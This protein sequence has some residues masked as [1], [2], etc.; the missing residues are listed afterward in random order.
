[1]QEMSD[2]KLVAL[3]RAGQ[4]E[5]FGH[6]LQRYQRMARFVAMR[7]VRDDDTACEM[8]QQAALQAYLSFRQLRHEGSFRSWFHGIVRNVC[9]SHA[10]ARKAVPISLDGLE[11]EGRQFDNSHSLRATPDPL[12]IAEK[13]Q[14][15]RRV[16]DAVNALPLE[17]RSVILLFYYDHLNL[18]EIALELNTTVPAVKN[19][20]YKSRK[21][22]IPLLLPLNPEM[23][24]KYLHR[25]RSREMKTVTVADV[26]R[27]ETVGKG[28]LSFVVLIDEVG[29]RILSIQVGFAEGLAISQ[30]LE[31]TAREADHIP[32]NWTFAEAPSSD[33]MVGVLEAT[34]V[35]LKEVRIEALQGSTLYGVA[36]LSVSGT[37]HEVEA[38]PSDV[39]SLAVR[40]GS[41]IYVHE[42]VLG[43]A[44]ESIPKDLRETPEMMYPGARMINQVLLSRPVF[45]ALEKLHERFCE[46]L[47]STLSQMLGEKAR[48]CVAY[49]DQTPYNKFVQE[50][51]D[52]ACACQF[53]L[54][55]APQNALLDIAPAIARRLSDPSCREKD[56]PTPLSTGDTR[57]ISERILTDLQRVWEPL[58]PVS[59]GNVEPQSD[60]DAIQ[61][62]APDAHLCVVA[63]EIDCADMVELIWFCYPA[64]TL[65]EPPL[66]QLFHLV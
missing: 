28:T 16:L 32:Y 27:K 5:A 2:V 42:D 33:F 61:L 59:I 44:G 64:A 47:A 26:I 54:G 43:K 39:L 13:R 35:E 38:R 4:K 40:T 41:P 55:D 24:Q 36:K 12:E 30:G 17:S 18:Q 20:L 9:L 14:L 21:Q 25:L 19:R 49:L 15:D 48:V 45:V 58:L 29:K 56:G 53:T 31:R 52:P 22:L 10:R 23:G 3:A 63:L 57:R 1:M 7:I 62:T 65:L 37:V 46:P 11:E 51:S 34:G 50:M 6:L 60:P 66:S 8:V